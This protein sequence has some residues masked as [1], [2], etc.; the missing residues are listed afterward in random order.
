MAKDRSGQNGRH[1]KSNEIGDWQYSPDRPICTKCGRPARYHTKN[2]DGSIKWWRKLCTTCQKE[3]INNSHYGHRLFKKNYCEL[4]GFVAINPVQLD[5]DH[6]NG[7]HNDRREE[8]LMTL[9]ANCHRLKTYLTS[10]HNGIEY[11][12]KAKLDG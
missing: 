2:A 1:K 11:I 4:C 6:I 8:N 5:V 9:C 12:Q 7:N 3:T 10:E